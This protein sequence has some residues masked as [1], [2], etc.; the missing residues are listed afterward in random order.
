[1]PTRNR[2]L[3]VQRA[4]GRDQQDEA[5][6]DAV[7]VF[8]TSSWLRS[9]L[10]VLKT[11]TPLAGHVVRDAE[12]NE[13]PSELTRRGHL[14]LL[15]KDVPPMGVKRFLIGPGTPQSAGRATAA[16]NVISNGNVRV[17]VDPQTGA[18]ASFRWADLPVDLVDRAV[19]SGWNDYRYVAGRDPKDARGSR[20][21]RIEVL[22]SGGLTASLGVFSE[23]PGCKQLITIIRVVDGLDRVDIT[24]V[25][26]KE[27]VLGKESV[28][29]GF[30]F[31]VPDGVMRIDIPWAVIRP[32]S[33]Q[34]PGA[35]KNYLTVGRW[36]DISN[37][38]FGVTWS[39]L[40][41]PLVEVG[42]IHVDVD[43]PFTSDAWIRQLGSTQTFYSYVMN[44]YWE[45]NYKASQEGMTSF[46][47][48]ILPHR[49]YDQAAAARFGMER[50]Q[51]LIAVPARR[52]TPVLGSRLRVAG[53]DIVVTSLK[54]TFD[55]QG[56]VVRL[57]NAGTQPAQAS[58]VWSDPR[59]R[60]TTISSPREETGPEVTGPIE[61]PPLGIL[62]LRADF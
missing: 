5:A 62:T 54:P 26:D 4:L 59:P 50:S 41:A 39:T 13:V 42:G 1:M 60:R 56:L 20:A 32:D 3:L 31:Q 28:H 47:Y 33:D 34:L 16:G 58:V 57:F 15:A 49:E 24:N 19:G 40:D 18:I 46:R 9:D 43:N 17:E 45:T 53:Q 23:A 37:D 8:N 48:S 55:R 10:V 61:L 44:N 27:K 30:P 7:D 2:S 29:I 6:I 11:D 22:S 36:I 51:P 14:A 35:C 38:Q 52:E 12:G 25:L 21:S